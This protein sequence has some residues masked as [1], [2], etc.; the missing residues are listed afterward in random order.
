MLLPLALVL[1]LGATP[2]GSACAGERVVLLPFDSVALTR[3]EARRTEEAVRRALARTPGVCLET[4]KQTVERLRAREGKQETCTEPSCRASQVKAFGAEWLVRG[5]VL[6]LGG[7]RTVSLALEGVDGRETRSTFQVPSLDAGAE[8]AAKRA[9][10][11]LWQERHPQQPSSKKLRTLPMVLLGTGVAA[12]AA[13]VGF[14]L[15][16]HSTEQ[17][18]SQGTGACTGTGDD[19]RR[20]FEDGLHRGETQT[21]LANGLLGAG[22]VLGAGGAILLIWELP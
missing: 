19:F 16:A 14:G 6:G 5:R 8:E 18:F 10:T 7:E 2:Q 3:P 9:F 17:R 11:G 15:A 21:H 12:L 1:S 22:A 13:G 20:C 4:R